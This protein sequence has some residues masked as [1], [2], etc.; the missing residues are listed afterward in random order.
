MFF[1]FFNTKE[2]SFTVIFIP[3]LQFSG[4]HRSVCDK[5]AD[6]NIFDTPKSPYSTFNFQYSNEAF[7]RLHNLME[8]NTLM[9]SDV[10]K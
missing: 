7:D 3:T 9:H 2:R 5:S 10:S 4:V 1:V 8:F 6:F